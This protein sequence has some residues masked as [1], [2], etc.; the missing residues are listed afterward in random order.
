L[1]R[2]DAEPILK[3]GGV[4]A[5]EIQRHF[6]VAFSI[7]IEKAGRRSDEP[8]PHSR[9]GEEHRAGGAVVGALRTVL[10]D[11]PSEFTETKDGHAVV[12]PGVGEIVMKSAQGAGEMREKFGVP[13][14]LYAVRVVARL[15]GVV[16]SGAEPCS[17]QLRDET[18]ALGQFRSGIGSARPSRFCH[19]CHLIGEG[20]RI[21]CTT[22]DE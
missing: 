19:R 16:D 4:H 2:W 22:S 14:T 3:Y 8:T 15:D 12:E 9:A 10:F 11:P 20:I 13:A 18:E 1:L 5:S 17:N 21:Q 7:E 6:Q